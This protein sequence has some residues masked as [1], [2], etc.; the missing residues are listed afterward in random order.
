MTTRRGWLW[1]GPGDAL[2]A[3]VLGLLSRHETVVGARV[4][5]SWL[6]EAVAVD[7]ASDI[8]FVDACSTG[9]G[10]GVI[11][12]VGG[13]MGALNAPEDDVVIGAGFAPSVLASALAA[14]PDGDVVVR[15]YRRRCPL[16]V[17]GTDGAV[18]VAPLMV[19]PRRVAADIGDRVA[20]GCMCR[21]CASARRWGTR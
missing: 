16:I 2:T 8:V 6:R 21:D 5:L 14:L 9:D 18:T 17:L 1:S 3:R 11:Q 19:C 7:A 10:R 12:V 13:E 4:D 15:W 20:D